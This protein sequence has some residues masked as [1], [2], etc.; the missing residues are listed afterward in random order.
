MERV[1]SSKKE[2]IVKNLIFNALSEVERNYGKG[3]GDGENSKGYHNRTHSEEVLSAAQR[4]AQLSLIAG[5]I[6]D[7]DVSLIEIAACFHDIEQGLGGGLNEEQSARLAEEEMKNARLFGEEDIQKVRRMILAT[8]VYFEDG[9][10]KQSATKEYLTQIMADADL[11]GLGQETNAFWSGALGRLREIEQ[12][13][14]PSREDE[15]AFTQELVI[16]LENHHFYTREAN[17][18]FPHKQENIKFMKEH[19]RELEN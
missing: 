10:A 16:F 15:I 6:G 18:L 8:T 2:I 14:I 11:S 7:S 13:D 12:T 19:I 1:N 17:R 3:E 5:K 4:I 9:I